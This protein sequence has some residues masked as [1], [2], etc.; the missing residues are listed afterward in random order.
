[1]NFASDNWSGATPAVMAALARHNQG[2]APAYGG[3]AATAA[4]ERRFRD[5]FETEVRR[6]R[7]R[8]QRAVA[9]GGGTAGWARLLRRDRAHL[10]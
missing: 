9:G 2:F 6:L 5:L 7:N 1:M 4:I 8:R 10:P 3:D